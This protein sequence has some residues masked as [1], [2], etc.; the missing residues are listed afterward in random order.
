[1]DPDRVAGIILTSSIY[2]YTRGGWPHPL[3]LASFAAYDVPK[4]GETVVKTRRAAVDPETFVR[5]GLRMLTVDPSAVP[6]GPDRVCT[7]TLVG[8][9]RNEPEAT[10][11]FL[12]AARSINAY[13]RTPGVGHRAMSN[14][15]CPVLVIHGR[16]DRFVPV[17]YA[18]AAL[19]QVPELARA[20]A[21]TCRACAADG[22]AGRWLG[23]VA[24]WYAAT[25]R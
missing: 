9:L 10:D 4:L 22:G 24:D 20:T 12:D 21:R 14:V 15:R 19:V 5:L 1:M 16:R 7:R 13:V 3:V 8:D 17:T 25:L 2:P 6:G 23:E 18:E 11:A